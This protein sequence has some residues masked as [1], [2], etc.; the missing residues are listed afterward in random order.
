M[1][2]LFSPT[3]QITVSSEIDAKLFCLMETCLSALASLLEII[4]FSSTSELTIFVNEMLTYIRAMVVH[5]PQRSVVCIKQLIKLMFSMN[6]RNR[7]LQNNLYDFRKLHEL[8]E[9]EIFEYFECF[10]TIV[11]APVKRPAEATPSKSNT[12][13]NFLASTP[14]KTPKSIEA[15]GQY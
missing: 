11:T 3:I 10:K 6:Y 1:L 9:R 12:L 13:I 15:G 5:V 7:K 4:E 2:Y 14:E 8:S